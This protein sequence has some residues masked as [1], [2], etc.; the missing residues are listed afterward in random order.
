MIEI[1][2]LPWRT[3]RRARKKINDLIAVILGILLGL[4]I[5][6]GIHHD[7]SNRL[8]K[9]T[10]K[11]SS[12]EKTLQTSQDPEKQIIKLKVQYEK[13]FKQVRFMQGLAGKQK[14][15]HRE[16]SELI[17]MIGSPLIINEIRQ[18]KNVITI[19]G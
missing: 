13:L 10:E 16:L 6:V 7:F 3:E 19:K 14:D 8:N 15:A 17:I 12:L 1:N 18:V 2:L 5:L 9:L 11:S 4:A